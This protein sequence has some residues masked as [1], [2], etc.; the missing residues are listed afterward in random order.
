MNVMV[1]RLSEPLRPQQSV[2]EVEQ[3]PR[4]HEG[5]ERIVEDHGALPSEPIAGIGVAHRQREEAEPDGE[6]YDVQHLH[7]PGDR[8]FPILQQTT[9]GEVSL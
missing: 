9:V 3:Q 5:G 2:G 7:A 8:R 1:V 6:H 4:S